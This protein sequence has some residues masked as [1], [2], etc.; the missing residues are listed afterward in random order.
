MQESAPDES[1]IGFTHNFSVFSLP[2]LGFAGAP[3]P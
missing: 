3:H 2:M 1:S